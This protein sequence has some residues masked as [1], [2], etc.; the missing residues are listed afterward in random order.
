MAAFVVCVVV[1]IY[2][3]SCLCVAYILVQGE[4]YSYKESLR[5]SEYKVEDVS[6]R[7]VMSKD[8]RWS[9]QWFLVKKSE[10]TAYTMYAR[11]DELKRRWIKAIQEAL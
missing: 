10:R 5:L 9:F 2:R 8:T 1:F 3:C 4:Q 11:T 6:N 7:R